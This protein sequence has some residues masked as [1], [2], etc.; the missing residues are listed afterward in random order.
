[1]LP[2]AAAAG[3]AAPADRRSRPLEAALRARGRRERGRAQRP[4]R[5]RRV[6]PGRVDSRAGGAGGRV[7]GIRAIRW[8]LVV[9]ATLA[10]AGGQ[11]APDDGIT[12]TDDSHRRRGRR[13]VAVAR[14]REPRFQGGV[15]RGQRQWRRARPAVRLGHPH[16]PQRRAG[17]RAGRGPADDRRRPRLRARQLQRPG[18]RRHRRLRPHPARAAAVPAHR[19]GVLRGRTLPVHVVPAVRRGGGG[20]VPLS[21]QG[22]RRTPAG[23]CP[24][25]QR[26]RHALP[27]SPPRPCRRLRLHGDRR[28]GDRHAGVR[29]TCRRNSRRWSP[30][31]PTRS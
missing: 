15:R 12:D 9:T 2:M 19:A 21:R 5:P 20:D 23:H 26:L 29:P 30:R 10:V 11:A 16:P 31:R 28:R 8:A 24:R 3:I 13:R 27:R 22:A 14:R 4:A 25:P 6:G 1:M 7:M 18:D 17:R